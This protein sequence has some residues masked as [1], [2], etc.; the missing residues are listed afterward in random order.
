MK[1]MHN[2]LIKF[3]FQKE[4]EIIS[5]YINKKKFKAKS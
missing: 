1:Q 3:I 5:T 4:V 2:G